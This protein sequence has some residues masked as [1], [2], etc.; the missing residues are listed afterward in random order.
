M[1]KTPVRRTQVLINN[2]NR[3]LLLQNAMNFKEP[4]DADLWLEGRK[5]KAICAGRRK[6]QAKAFEEA[7]K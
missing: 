7:S 1:K 3:S 4:T 2:T 6:K 5:A